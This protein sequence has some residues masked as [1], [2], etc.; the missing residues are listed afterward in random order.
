MARSDRVSVDGKKLLRRPGRLSK[1]GVW[2]P[3]RQQ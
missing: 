1:V 2:V 3:H